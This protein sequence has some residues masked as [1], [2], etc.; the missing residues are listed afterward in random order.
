MGQLFGRECSMGRRVGSERW[1]SLLHVREANLVLKQKSLYE[2]ESGNSWGQFCFAEEYFFKDYNT[3]FGL[4]GKNQTVRLE[5]L[6]AH[7]ESAEGGRVIV[8]VDDKVAKVRNIKVDSRLDGTWDSREK[9]VAF[10]FDYCYWSVDPED[11]KYASQEMVFQDLGTSVLSGAFRGYNICLFAYGQTGSGKTYTMMGTPASIGLTPRICEGLFSRKDDYSDQTA[12]CRVKVSF[13]EIYNERVRDL[14]KQSDRKKPYTLRVREHP[15]TGPYVQG[16]T[17]HLV[18]DYK[19][20]VELLEEG[21]AKRITAATHIHNASSRS[22]AIF[23]IHYTQA[24]LENNLPSEIAS[25]INLVDLAGSERADPSYCKDR[26]TEGANINKS[27]VTLG[28]VISTLAQN[29]QMFSSCQSINTI[30]SEGESSHADSPSTGSIS[31]TR[32]PAYIPYRDSI[33]TWL[34]KDSLGGNS[35]TIMIATISPASSSYNETMSTLRYASNAKNIINKPRVNEDANV[36]LIRELREEIDRLK[37]MLMSFEL[38]NS[39]PSWSDDRD[40]NLTELVL[41]NEMKI[42]QLTKDWTS[43]W[44]DR[45]AIMEEYSVDINKEKA[46]V[47]IDS[48]LPHLMAMDDDILSTGVVLYHLREGTTKIGRSDSDQDQDIVLQGR[49]IERDHCMID[50]NCGIV[51]LRPVQGAHCTVNGCEVTGSCRL[52]QGALVVLGKSHK[53]RFNHPAE[54]AILRQRRSINETPRILSC[55]ALDWLNLDGNCTHSPQ[56]ILSSLDYAKCRS[57]KENKC[58]PELSREIDA[59]REEYKQ[60]LRDQEAFHRKQIQRQQLYVED[61]KQQILR[62]QI[63]AEQELEND[64]ALIN[65]QIQENQQWLINE[66]KRLAALQQQQREFAVQTESTL[67]AEAEVQSTIGLEICPSLL[68]Q[69]KKRLVQLELLRRYSLKKA[70]RNIRRKKVKFQLERIVK[71]QKLLEAKQ[72]LEQLEAS[73]WLNEECVKQSQVLN[74]NTAVRSSSDH[75]LEKRR[76]SSGSSSLQQRQHLFCNSHLPQVPGFLLKRETVSKLPTSPNIDQCCEGSTTGRLSSAEYPYRRG[77]DVSGSDDFNDEKGISFSVHRQLIEKQKPSSFGNR[78][79]AEK[80]SNDSAIMAY[81]NKK[82]QKIGKLDDNAGQAGSQNQTSKGYSPDFF[83]EK[84]EPETFITGA[85]MT[86]PKVLGD[87]SQHA[88]SNLEQNRSQVSNQKSRMH[89]NGKGHRSSPEKFPKEMKKTVY[90]NPPSAH[91]NQTAKNWKR[92]PN[93]SLPS[94]EESSVEQQEFLMVATSVGNLTKMNTQSPLSYVE[95]KWHSA[96]L[97]SAGVSKTA[98]DVLENWQE[99]DENDISDTDSS[100]SV[101]SLSCA[102]GKAFTE[103]LKQEDCDRNKCLANPEDSE[104]DDSQMSQDSL[105]EKENKAKKQNKSR[106]HESKA[107]HEPAKLYKS[108]TDHHISSFVTSYISHRRLGKPE[109]SFSLDSLADGEEMPAEDPVEESKSDSSDEVPAEIFWKLQTPRSPTTQTKEDHV[110]KTCN[111]DTEGTNYDLKLSS[112]FY[113]DTKPQPASS[114]A[115]KQL[116]KG[117]KVSFVEQERSLDR[118]LYYGSG[119]SL[120]TT[121]AWSSCDSKVDISSPRITAPSSHENLEFQEAHLCSLSKPEPWLKKDDLK[122]SAAE[123]SFV[124]GSKQIHRITH[125]SHHINEINTV[126]TSDTSEVPLPETTTTASRVPE[127][128]SLNKILKGWTNSNENSSLESQ[129]VMSSFVS[130]VGSSSSFVPISEKHDYYEHSRS[131]HPE[132]EQLNEL[133]TYRSTTECTQTFSCL[134]STSTADCLSLIPRKEEDSFPTTHPELPKDRNMKKTAFISALPGHILEQRN[135][136][137]DA[138]LEDDF[139]RTFEKDGLDDDYNNSMTK[140]SMTDSGSGSASVSAPDAESSTG[141]APNMISTQTAA[142]KQVQFGNHGQLFPLREIPTCCDE[143]FFLSDLRN[144]NCSVVSSYELQT[145]AEQGAESAVTVGLLRSGEANLETMQETDYEQISAE[146]IT[147]ETD[148]SSEKTTYRCNPLVVAHSASYDQSA[149]PIEMSQKDMICMEI[150]TDSLAEIVPEVPSF[151]GNEKYEPKDEDLS[152]L[153]HYEFKSKPVSK[154]YSHECALADSR[155]SCLSQQIP[156]N[157]TLRIDNIREESSESK[158]HVL[159]SQAVLQKEFSSKYENLVVNEVSYLIVNVNGKDTESFPAAIYESTNDF[160]PESNSSIFYKASTKANLFQSASETENYDEVLERV[161]IVKGDCDATS[162]LT[163]EVSATESCSDVHSGCLCTTCSSK[164]TGQKNSMHEM[165]NISVEFD[166]AI[167]LETE[168]QNKSFLESREEEEAFFES[169]CPE[170]I[171]LVDNDVNSESGTVFEYNTNISATVSQEESLYTNKESKFLRNPETNLEETMLPYQNTKADTDE[172]VT[173]LMNSA[174]NFEKNALETKSRRIEDLPDYPVAK[175]QS[176]AEDGRGE[177]FKGISLSE[178]PKKAVD[179]V[180]CEVQCEFYTNLRLTHEEMEKDELQVASTGVEHTQESK[181]LMHSGSRLETSSFCQK[182]KN[183]KIEIGIY[184]PEFSVAPKTTPS[185]VCSHTTDMT[186]N[187]SRFLDTCEELLQMNRIIENVFNTEDV[188]ATVLITSR[189]GNILAKPENEGQ[190]NSSNLIEHCVPNCLPQGDKCNECEVTGSEEQTVTTNTEGLIITRQEVIRT[191]EN[192]L[193]TEESPAVHQMYCDRDDKEEILNQFRIP[194]RYLT[195]S[196]LEQNTLLEDDSKYH[197]PTE[198]S[199]DGGSVDSVTDTRNAVMKDIDAYEYSVDDSTGIDQYRI[200]Q[201]FK[202]LHIKEDSHMYMSCSMQCPEHGPSENLN[203][204]IVRKR[205]DICQLDPVGSRVEEERVH[206][207]NLVQMA[208]TDKEKQMFVEN[209]EVELITLQNLNELFPEDKDSCQM[210]CDDSRLNEILRKSQWV[211][212]SFSRNNED[213]SKQQKPPATLKSIEKSQDGSLKDSPCQSVNHLLDLGVSDDSH[214]VQGGPTALKGHTKPS[215]SSVGTGAVLPYYETLMESEVCVATPDTVNKTG[216]EDT[217]LSG[218]MQSK[219]VAFLQARTIQDRQEEESFVFYNAPDYAISGQPVN[220][221]SSSTPY[222]AGGPKSE[223]VVLQQGAKGNSFSLEKLDSSKDIIQDV[224]NA[225]ENHSVDLMVNK[226]SKD[227]LNSIED[228]AQEEKGTIVP[229]SL[230]LDSSNLLSYSEKEVTEDTGGGEMHSFLKISSQN[231]FHNIN[232]TQKVLHSG[233]LSQHDEENF[234]ST[235]Y[236]TTNSTNEN[237]KFPGVAGY[238]HEPR[239][240]QGH[241]TSEECCVDHPGSTVSDNVSTLSEEFLNYNRISGTSECSSGRLNHPASSADVF[242]ASS[243]DK[244]ENDAVLTEETKYFESKSTDLSVS[245]TFLDVSQKGHERRNNSAVVEAAYAQNNKLPEK[246]VETDQKEKIIQ[247]SFQNCND[248]KENK[249]H[250][251]SEHYS[252]T[253][254]VIVPEPGLLTFQSQG[255]TGSKESK[256][257]PS[258]FAEDTPTDTPFQSSKNFSPFAASCLLDDSK[259]LI[260]DQLEDSLQDTFLTEQVSSTSADVCSV[261]D[262]P[263]AFACA[264][265]PS[266]TPFSESYLNADIGHG[267]TGTRDILHTNILKHSPFSVLQIQDTQSDKAV[268]FDEP[269][270]A[271]GSILLSLA[272]ENRHCPVSDIDSTSYKNSAVD[273]EPVYGSNHKKIDNDLKVDQHHWGKAPPQE[274]CPEHTEK[275]LNDNSLLLPSLPFW[276][277]GSAILVKEGQMRKM[278][279]RNEEE[280]HSNTEAEHFAVKPEQRKILSREPV[281]KQTNE[282]SNSAN[283]LI[284]S[285]VTLL[286]NPYPGDVGVDPEHNCSSLSP[287]YPTYSRSTDPGRLYH[288]VLGFEKNAA[289]LQDNCQYVPTDEQIEQMPDRT[290]T[291]DRKE[292]LLCKNNRG[293]SIDSPTD[294]ADADNFSTTGDTI[295]RNKTLK[296]ERLKFSVMNN[297]STS[298]KFLPENHDFL[299][300]GSKLV[301]FRS[302]R[303]YSITQNMKSYKQSEQ[304]P[305]LQSH[306]LSAPAIAVFSDTEYA[307][308]ASS[309]ADPLLYSASKSLQDLN[310]SVE[311]PS[312][313]EDDLHGIERFSKQ[314]SKNFLQVKSKPRFQQRMAQTKKLANCNPQNLQNFAARTQSSQTLKDC[315]TQSPSSLL[316]TA[317][318]SV[319]A[320]ANVH[321]KS[322]SV[323]QCSEGKVEEAGYQPETDLV[324]HDNKDTMHFS[325]SDINPYIHPWQQD[326]S[327]KIG[328]KQYV[329]GSASDVSCNQIPLNLENRKVVRCS[330]VDNG[331]NSQNS[332]FHSH[333]SSYATAKVLSSTLSSIEGI[334][335]WDNVKRDFQSA[336]SSDSTKQYSKISS[337]TLETNP[338]NNTVESENSSAQTGNSSMQVDEIVLLY[339]SESEKPSRKLPGITCEQGTQTATTGRYKRQR[340]HQRSYTDVSARKQETNRDLFHQPSS[341]T[342][343]QNL[344]MHL[345]QLL[346]NTSELLGNLSQQS[347]KDNEQNAKISQRG[348]EEAVKATRSDSCTQTT[349]DVGTQT[350]ILEE[351]QS[352]QEEKQ[353]EAKMENELRAVQAVNIDRKGIGAD[354]VDKIPKRKDETL[355][356]EERTQERTEMRNLG[357]PDFH[358]SIDSILEDSFMRLPLLPRTSTPVLDFQKTSLNAQQNVAFASTRVSSVTSSLPSSGQ[359]GSSC[360]VVSSST[361]STSR[362]PASYAQDK[363]SVNELEVPAERKF[364][365]KNTLLVDRASSPILTL[366]ASPSSQTAFS[367]SVCPIKEPLGY[368]SGAS[369]PLHNQRQQRAGL[370]SSMQPHVDNFSQTE[371]DSESSTSKDNEGIR[372]KSGSFSNKKAAK[373]L[374]GQ[375][376]SKDLEQQRRLMVDTHTTICAKRLYHSSSML[377]VSGHREFLTGDLGDHSPLA[378]SLRCTYV[379]RGARGSSA[380]IGHESYVGNSDTS[381][382]HYSPPNAEL[383]FNQK[384]SATCS[385]KT[386]AGTSSEP[387]VE[388]SSLQFHDFFWKNENSCPPPLSDVSDVQTSFQD[389]NTDSVT[390]S[391]CDTEIPLNKSTTFAKPYRP[392]SYSLRDLPIH[393]KFSNWCGVKGSPSP[394]LLSLSSSVTDLRSQAEKKPRSTRATETEGKP[395][396]SDS[397]SREIERLQ[398]ERAQIMSGIHLDLHQHP[399]T[400][401]LTEAK[402]NYGIG[403][404]DALLRVLQSG[405]ADDLVAIPVKQQLYERHMRTIETLRKEREKRLQRYQ[406]SRSLSPQKHLSLLQ[407]L[408]ASQRDLDLPS[409]RREYLQQLRRDVVENTRV[410]EPK[411]RSVQHPS[412]I[413]LLLRDYQ[414]ARE[415]TKTEIARARDKLR[416][417]AEQEKRRIREQIFSQLQKEEARLKTLASTST[418][419]TDSSLSLSSG[420][421][422][423]YNSSNTATYTA[424]NL[425][426]QEGQVSSGNALFSRDTR[427]R[428]AVRNSQLYVLEQLQKDPTIEASRIQPPLPSSSISCRFTHGLTISV[429]SSS[430][431]GYQDLSKHILANA[432]T[433]VMAACS[434]NLR[435]LYTCQAAAGWKYQ[436]T[437]KEV[438]VYYKVFPSATRHGFLGAGVIERPLPYVWGLVRDPGKRHLYDRTIN[439]ARIHKKVTSHIQLVYLVTDTSLCYLK[440]PRDFCCITVEAKEENLSVLAI[441]SVYD[442]SMP[443]PCKEVVRGEILPSAWILEPDVVNGRDI[444]RVIYMAQVD[445]GA[446]AIPARLLSSIAKRQPLVIARLAHFLAS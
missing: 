379:T 295:M 176:V 190:V 17:Q 425:S 345:S 446:P 288:T 368:S 409:R 317:H 353:V 210:T 378:R 269:V 76:K 29:S 382:I 253:S 89:I 262:F 263:R 420:P 109:R 218:R 309:K 222:S 198:M 107:H 290:N 394:S 244:G 92:E 208:K 55:G 195:A 203:A 395:Q 100:Y 274:A 116:L 390:E 205:P 361:N 156:E 418:L 41:Q 219:N 145:L 158:E 302:K 310:M 25:K 10:S 359:G 188:A 58:S 252:N 13:L 363:R 339:P 372:K 408:D 272:K 366:S 397:R 318:S 232:T 189:Q 101:D 381:L 21:I 51:T 241:E 82:D 358:D 178:N 243:G 20:V 115:C 375:D 324:L 322:S 298:V 402:L 22:H 4:C 73:C 83:K 225:H 102:Y 159:N 117:T 387:L 229:D 161:T 287:T 175:V 428:S 305:Y 306:R 360:T 196:G 52:S 333:L 235:S 164:S 98:T 392:R 202:S 268:V 343:M 167:L 441:Q 336:Y 119:N 435:N 179:I 136:C 70:E 155:A 257:L 153:S 185:A 326:G 121:D 61:L 141:L 93:S 114:N 187:T 85:R 427:G 357:N 276:D 128:G 152:S 430:T 444:T 12:S 325:S 417:R 443:H 227:C 405:T 364:S 258:Y 365:Y 342:S 248:V 332:P 135:G 293:S 348:T 48:S 341:W 197:D 308:E 75:H 307:L 182:E 207:M 165:T 376:G 261:K 77:K 53:F 216:G 421:T 90:G 296:S 171:L 279:N 49:W 71:K 406:R 143:G 149:T 303:S 440:Q 389:D 383:L 57:C 3:Y 137:V 95:K 113:L 410:Q 438:L 270:H 200:E 331:L 373:E 106:V 319:G 192:V 50:N 320:E 99:D 393:N 40:G 9:T 27:L 28:I 338:E 249:V 166:A 62:G 133:F 199:E 148:F 371:T 412:D 130:S 411:R 118:R 69:D 316:H 32:R 283:E 215:N 142:V 26:I 112:S 230:L 154:N 103:K 86:K 78:K 362:S 5:I 266:L 110:S 374:L 204:S 140:S 352:K 278:L 424:S 228:T 315:T 44:T 65:Q 122:Q 297:E 181:A 414:R 282:S 209:P 68:Q 97:L 91:L 355:C 328:W 46:G 124:S 147:T 234:L 356:L 1:H 231:M 66:N 84:D 419:C 87:L 439:T 144:K 434:H 386:N 30:T 126:F 433:E 391:E 45:K 256:S 247:H 437:E 16:L 286:E 37:S 431:K 184:S 214:L 19:Q 146:E 436:C 337:E 330:S 260:F 300:Q 396:L 94:H 404:T 47:T 416:E 168:T 111:R 127:T 163:V 43:K 157:S 347:V 183:E 301:Q 367:K 265:H 180:A 398:R 349:A 206:L 15:E 34:L 211:S 313:T 72:N 291:D 31:G 350:E 33:L 170:D 36:K 311:P 79:E 11:P 39:S 120:L 246:V 138:D 304:R 220:E 104:S 334:Q 340:R 67:Y 275:V 224:N 422:S 351:H 238:Q 60:K 280:L 2:G 59:V 264:N 237:A 186:Q 63:R 344:S 223:T 239:E 217:H 277:S 415:E 132:Q 384:I 259:S 80:D 8:E 299:P 314:E 173:K 64:Q 221:N 429:S 74:E 191:D 131:N 399:L 38:R 323:V 321:S 56:Y 42:E 174:I 250:E 54:A 150:S 380:G 125:L 96:E 445:L 413:E 162:N 172:E 35:K 134:E 108:G 281:E 267:E 123:V 442:A 193:F 327:C 271:S 23:T 285:E 233:S 169:D 346:Q 403:E 369:S 377:E 273:G 254:S 426:S 400:V 212:A 385:N 423:G 151:R 294:D 81:I 292:F 177:D 329:F 388:A 407:T 255:Q 370:Q 284:G 14:L 312:P 194:E 160:L 251:Y 236:T 105:V 289:D 7:R 226:L 201:E 213:T 24:I 354:A 240:N 432:T 245:V 335:G 139:L 88:S 18:T 6:V 401:E 242:I 129:D